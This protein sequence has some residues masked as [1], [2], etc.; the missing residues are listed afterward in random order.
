M[1]SYRPQHDQPQ[2]FEQQHL[3]DSLKALRR[4]LAAT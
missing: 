2:E 3:H 1:A 4:E